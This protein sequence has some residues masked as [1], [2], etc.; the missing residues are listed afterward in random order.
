[1]DS[2][3]PPI[4]PAPEPEPLPS[5]PK[6]IGILCIAYASVGVF[7]YGACGIPGL[8]LQGW[9]LSLSGI[10]APPVPRVMLVGGVVQ[11]ALGLALGILLLVAGLRL[12]RY[13]RSARPLLL[14]WSVVRLALLVGSLLF[15]T[16]TLGTQAAYQREVA[17]AS[18]DMLR[19][20][21]MSPGE[22]D[23]AVPVPSEEDAVRSMRTWAISMNLP[24]GAFPLF[25]GLLATSGRKREEFDRFPTA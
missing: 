8:L 23:Q 6:T 25:I 24:L 13:R 9:L 20:R 16:M 21:G 19:G 3:A 10:E 15:A 5:W 22:I 11:S 17:E 4:R 14:A 2:S 7:F 12:F 1:V 18:R